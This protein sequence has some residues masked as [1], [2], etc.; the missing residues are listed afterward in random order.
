MIVS[1]CSFLSLSLSSSLSLSLY[2]SLSLSLSLVMY[3]FLKVDHLLLYNHSLTHFTHAHTH[4]HLSLVCPQVMETERF[5]YL[6][7][8]YASKGEIF[9]KYT[10]HSV[11]IRQGLLG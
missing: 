9:G 3:N 4:V 7:T 1:A 6:V 11:A 2:L 10:S 8:E 5:L